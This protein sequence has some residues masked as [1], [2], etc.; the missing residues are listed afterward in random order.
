MLRKPGFQA[1]AEVTVHSKTTDRDS[2]NRIFCAKNP[3]QIHAVAIGQTDIAD[4]QIER[5]A[6]AGLFQR[7]SHAVSSGDVV[8]AKLEETFQ[9]GAGVR[10]IVDEK[11]A[12][13]S[14]RRLRLSGTRFLSFFQLRGFHR[15]QKRRSAVQ[16]VAFGNE[17]RAMGL[18][19]RFGNSQAESEP[20]EAALERALALLERIE[21]FL[22][23][24]RLD[25]DAGVRD[26]DGENVR[27]MV[28]RADG[29]R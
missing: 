27:Q 12:K 17:R 8:A 24:L 25:P 6:G 29:D 23:D 22:H 9:G 28:R 4:E 21:D 18:G 1:L 19:E 15:E 11:N 26:G 7:V 2:A 13:T 5:I 20:A 16:S 14:R 10:M 3:E